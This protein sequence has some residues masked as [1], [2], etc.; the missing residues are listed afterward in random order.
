M[1]FDVQSFTGT[2][3]A[4]LKESL[5]SLLRLNLLEK[6]FADPQKGQGVQLLLENPMGSGARYLAIFTFYESQLPTIALP[7]PGYISIKDSAKLFKSLTG[8]EF[9]EIPYQEPA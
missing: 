6:P 7:D 5:I 1:N 4:C 9:I 8:T 2:L 3:K